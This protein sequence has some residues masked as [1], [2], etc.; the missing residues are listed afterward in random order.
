MADLH[1]V[2]AQD[3]ARYA[4]GRAV[5]LWGMVLN[6]LLSAFKI[7]SGILGRS[8]A[9]IADGIH[10]LS[11]L[12]SDIVVLVGLKV[13]AKP[14]DESHHYGHEKVEC[15]ATLAVAVLLVA[16]GLFI[17][18]E[19]FIGISEHHHAAPSLLPVVA[20][21]VSIVSKELLY[22]WTKSVGRRT[23]SSSLEANAWHHRTDAMTSVAVLAGLTIARLY[24]SLEIL[25]HLIA[26][27]V[28]VFVVQV[29][30]KIAYRDIHDLLDSAPGQE[31]MDKVC[32]SILG[33]DGVSSLHK[34]RARRVQ[35]RILIDVHIQVPGD[36]TVLEGHRISGMAADRVRH[37]VQNVKDVLIHIEPVEDDAQA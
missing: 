29:A 12:G 31:V 3:T 17:G 1:I 28:A 5:T 27:V 36:L 22:R 13:S 37:A 8:Q 24:P 35:G 25:D 9:I 19:S 33:V 32:E 21:A 20:A 16:A 34:C 11:D 15:L 14:S 4:A 23:G 26:L 18:Y 6:V 7:A 2:A 30:V 10:S